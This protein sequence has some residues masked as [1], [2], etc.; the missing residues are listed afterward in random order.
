MKQRLFKELKTGMPII[1]QGMGTKQHD[2]YFVISK[3]NVD[4]ETVDIERYVRSTAKKDQER[5]IVYSNVSLDH[6]NFI[7]TK[8][9][10]IGLD[11]SKF[12][13]K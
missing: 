4:N 12:F 5:N 8:D 2:F 7:D 9:K 6:I 13:P 11:A 10:L 3:I 1:Y